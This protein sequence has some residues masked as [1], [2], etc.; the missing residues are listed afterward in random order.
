[1]GDQANCFCFSGIW[2]RSALSKNSLQK[3]KLLLDGKHP[4]FSPAYNVM[5]FW[6]FKKTDYQR[7]SRFC[8]LTFRN[9]KFKGKWQQ[10]FIIFYRLI[11]KRFKN[12]IW[13]SI[14]KFLYLFYFGRCFHL[15]QRNTLKRTRKNLTVCSKSINEPSGCVNVGTAWPT[16]STSLECNQCPPSWINF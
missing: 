14:I 12:N 10:T 4:C 8:P 1:M 7:F 16:S 13:K 2:F 9:Q 6:I 3:K 15:N 5:D 11:W